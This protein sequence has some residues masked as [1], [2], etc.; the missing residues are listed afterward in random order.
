MYCTRCGGL[1]SSAGTFCIQCGQPLH[2]T[3][4]RSR[5]ALANILKWVG[6]VLGV[7][8]G[9]FIVL[10]VLAIIFGDSSDNQT[11]ASDRMVSAPR[12]V[13]DTLPTLTPTDVPTPIPVTAGMLS[14]DKDAKEVVWEKK[15]LDKYVL[16][17]G[18]VWSIED[19]GG[20]YD[21][22]L[23]ADFL[24]NV[25]CKVAKSR[26]SETEVLKLRKGNSVRVLGRVT[27]KGVIDIVVEDCSIDM[28]QRFGYSN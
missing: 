27:N 21:V 9:L 19:A 24:T 13:A 8:G 3:P 18:S 26:T 25:V 2:G 1:N 6:I 28:N 14:R 22:K 12:P 11:N 15:Y 4:H 20:K 23:D 16:V 17:S 7:M 10:V 5:Y